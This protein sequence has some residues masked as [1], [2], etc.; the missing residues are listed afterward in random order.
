MTALGDIM[1]YSDAYI[2]NM[3]AV[4]ADGPR[5]DGVSNTRS[6]VVT[7]VSSK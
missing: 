7:G 4:N 2:V 6:S 5:V 1:T 3:T